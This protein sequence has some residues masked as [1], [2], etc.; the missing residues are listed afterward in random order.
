MVLR[1]FVNAG[2]LIC[3]QEARFFELLLKFQI[4]SCTKIYSERGDI[5]NFYFAF[6]LYST[7]SSLISSYKAT[8]GASEFKCM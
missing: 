1:S 2:K 6:G 7:N 4:F 5:Y 8:S 3:C